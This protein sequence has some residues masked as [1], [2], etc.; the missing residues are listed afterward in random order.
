V[1]SAAA[2]ELFPAFVQ[3]SKGEPPMADAEHSIERLFE[4]AIEIEYA[5]AQIYGSFSKLFAHVNGLEAFWLGLKED[6]MEHAAMLQRAQR[7][8]TAERLLQNP[9]AK[10]WNDV[11]GIQAM[12]QKDWIAAI[13]TLDNAYERAH[14]LEFSE[15][16]S[17]FLFL[18]VECAPADERRLLIRSAIDSHQKKLLDFTQSFGNK[19]WRE[20]ISIR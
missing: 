8:L 11:A 5:A 19:A 13:R 9:G 16:N 7:L 3:G 6:E 15:V 12:L 20:T 2:I 18:A 10:I 4:Y 14:S 17:I 1:Y